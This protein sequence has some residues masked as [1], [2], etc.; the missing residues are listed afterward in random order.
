MDMQGNKLGVTFK[1]M[2][3]NLNSM[4]IIMMGQT[5]V[6]QAFNDTTGYAMQGTAKVGSATAYKVVVMMVSGKKK[7]EYY[8]VTSG[9]FL[10]EESISTKIGI[11]ITQTT[12]YA[13]YKR[14][15]DVLFPYTMIQTVQSPQ[16]TQEFSISI[17]D[18]K[19][20]PVLQAADFN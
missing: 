19:V 6:K 11:E 7:T 10:K 9:L 8:D 4:E 14:V 2:A 17:K 16:A 18:I 15:G 1:K 3:P 20:N 12:E 5:V 13:D